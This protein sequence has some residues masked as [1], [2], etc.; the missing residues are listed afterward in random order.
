MN[1]ARGLLSD[2]PIPVTQ[3][4]WSDSISDS[5]VSR[6][7][8][9][10]DRRAW[11]A[12]LLTISLTV[13]AAAFLIG[14]SEDSWRYLGYPLIVGLP[15]AFGLLSAQYIRMMHVRLLSRRQAQLVIAS[16]ELTERAS[17]DDLTKLYNRYYF[18]ES[19]QAQL[20]R[21]RA[22]REP[23]ALLLLDIDGLKGIN[24][25][26]GHQVGDAIIANLGKL[27]AKHSR[28]SDVSAR[29]GGDEFGIVMPS[30]DKRGAFAMAQ[31]L[32]EELE[33]IPMYEAK[34]V[35]IM[36]NVSIGVSGY[37]W[38]GEDVDEMMHW[39]DADMYVNKASR[40]LSP[41]PVPASVP[42][43]LDSLPDD[44]SGFQAR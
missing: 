19:L 28:N 22:S 7:E 18:Y 43:D 41:Q 10:L 34:G 12:W 26:Y 44:F 6:E 32:W 23:L 3:S 11:T 42:G 5:D 8:A 14:R 33:Q 39:A 24:D 36:L 13:A 15:V 2:D 4:P 30:T 16:V 17:K 20:G 31:R 1:E 25:E 29:L 27:I 35:Y 21:A 37:P 9:K 38:G 40:R